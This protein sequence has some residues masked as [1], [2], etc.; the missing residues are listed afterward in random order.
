MSDIFKKNISIKFEVNRIFSYSFFK[1]NNTL[2]NRISLKNE[3]NE[4]YFDIIL[5]IFFD[6]DLVSYKEIFIKELQKKDT[7]TIEEFDKKV[8][9]DLLK[10]VTRRYFSKLNFELRDSYQNVI[11]FETVQI[12]V[13]PINF[14]SGENYS[15]ETIS[16]FINPNDDYIKDVI[17]RANK[18]SLKLKGSKF[19]GYQNNDINELK[20]EIEIVYLDVLKNKFKESEL[21][22]NYFKDGTYVKFPKEI[23]KTKEANT[24]DL[25]LFFAGIFEYL[26][27][28][29]ILVFLNNKVLVGVWANSETFAST[30]SDNNSVLINYS[31]EGEKRIFLF[32]PSSIFNSETF[33]K[34]NIKALEEIKKDNSFFLMLDLRMCR[35]NAFKPIL[36][37][38]KDL[39]E[40]Y[41]IDLKSLSLPDIDIEDA[42]EIIKEEDSK[43]DRF[44]IWKKKLLDLSLSNRLINMKIGVMSYQL[45]SPDIYKVSDLLSFSDTRI[46]L[47]SLKSLKAPSSFSKE[48]IDVKGEEIYRQVGEENLLQKR[49]Q[50]FLSEKEYQTCLT[51]LY[52]KT[53]SD[54]EE[55]GSNTLYIALGLV[56]WKQ[57][58]QVKKSNYA[59]IVLFPCELIKKPNKEFSIKVRDQEPILNTTFFAYLKE[60]FDIDLDYLNDV[61]YKENGYTVDLKL[62]FNTIKRHIV[63]EKGFRLFESAFIGRF[64]FSKYIMWND[65]KKKK[66][67]MLNNPLIRCFALKEGYSLPKKGIKTNDIDEA[68][69]IKDVAIPL[70]SDSSQIEAIIDAS[71]GDSFVLIGPPGT[72]KSQT[73]ANMIVNS[74][75]NGKKVLFCSE[76]KAALDVVYSRL[77]NLRI[78]PFCLEL[79]SNKQDKKEVLNSLNSTLELGEIEG[80][81]KFNQITRNISDSKEV[82]RDIVF[83][84]HST[85]NFPL[86]LYDAI[87]EYQKYENVEK[88]L[89]I[90]ETFV[91]SYTLNKHKEVSNLFRKAQNFSR[92]FNK[93]SENPFRIYEKR[94]YSLETKLSLKNL[95]SE[96][97]KNLSSFIALYKE[98]N[99]S[100]NLS[101]FTSSKLKDLS[102][103]FDDL[104][105]KE[106]IKELLFK[107]DPLK[108]LN[109]INDDLTLEKEAS[110]IK[111]EILK[112][113]EEKVIE[114]DVDRYLFLLEQN[115]SY[116]FIKKYFE[117]KKILKVFK[118][119]AYK[120][121]DVNKTNLNELLLN[122]ASYKKLR[123]DVKKNSI[124]LKDLFNNDYLTGFINYDELLTKVNNTKIIAYK[125]HSLTSEE[126]DFETLTNYIFELKSTKANR[127]SI[128]KYQYLYKKIDEDLSTLKNEYNFNFSSLK[129]ETYYV[130]LF[131]LF[132]G[133]LKNID[134]VNEWSNLLFIL[135]EFDTYELYKVKE[136]Y[137][138]DFNNF[139][140]LYLSFNKG[141][142]FKIIQKLIVENKLKNFLG[143]NI[144]EIKKEYV[145]LDK[146][147][148][149]EIIKEVVS[150]LSRNLPTF[151]N[152]SIN[153]SEVGILK[154]AILNKGRGLTLRKLFS[155]IPST[156]LKLTP[157]VLVSPISCA[158]YLDP[159]LYHFDVVIFDEASQLPTSDAIGV[160]SRGDSVII[161]GDD[162][163]LPP[164]S[165]FDRQINNEDE[166][167]FL[168]DLESVLDDAL[169]S[170]FEKK[171]LLYHYRS[172]NESLIAFSN[173]RFYENSLYTFPSSDEVESKVKYINVN[174]VYDSGRS[175]TNKEEANAIISN[176]KERVKNNPN[177]YSFGIIT[178]SIHQM[179]LIEDLLEEEL[180]KDKEF[181]EAYSSL[182]ESIFVK[183]LENVQGDERDIIYLSICYGRNKN[184]RFIQNFGPINNAGGYRR[185]NVAI[186]RSRVEMFVYSSISY[187]DI[188]LSKTN[189]EGAKYLKYF[190]EFAEHGLSSLAIRN[191]SFYVKEGIETYIASDLIKKGYEVKLHLGSSKFKIDIAVVSP[192]DK[193]SYLLAIIIDGY[194][195]ASIPTV[196]DR[197]IIEFNVLESLGWNTM[198]IWSLDYF[199]S[200]EKVISRIEERIQE[201]LKKKEEVKKIKE[202]DYSKVEFKRIEKQKEKLNKKYLKYSVLKNYNEN[203]F[204]A[205]VNRSAI[206]KIINSI[207]EVEAP[208]SRTIL[209]K[210]LFEIFAISRKSEKINKVIKFIFSYIKFPTSISYEE[211]FYFLSEEQIKNVGYYR[212]PSSRK[213]EEI[214]KEEIF[215]LLIEILKEEISIEE[216]A[217][218]KEISKRLGYKKFTIKQDEVLNEVISF[219]ENKKAIKRKENKFI[220]LV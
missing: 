160:I 91:D 23:I 167:L 130:E 62:V 159:N 220:E 44:S 18:E 155:L 21:P 186:T 163:Q 53:K 149:E 127:A 22:F 166:D 3:T 46:D 83:K 35:L 34:S 143:M 118:K 202:I 30:I 29:S 181:L 121:K 2:I 112:V 134:L 24:L 190:L 59:P 154:K 94:Y 1:G 107:K 156:I 51:N 128:E 39:E 4:D 100:L 116:N 114:E 197:N 73:I 142:Y 210:R 47:L 150:R 199:D 213:M 52:R 174:G 195:Y 96:V 170:N 106:V 102:L 194:Q 63:S 198:M 193:N 85:K 33:L 70:S 153:A 28:N 11:S 97:S 93:F 200:K 111:K 13:L 188:D 26:S 81:L 122:I 208:I 138:K 123:V 69:N 92:F 71:L 161:A 218:K 129:E 43:K 215:V 48:L 179:N 49:I 15:F 165:F 55:T 101:S 144:D 216:S 14:F 50:L 79:H 147:Y 131:N 171:N 196:K 205:S 72:G 214:A 65:I 109:K 139:D 203:Q 125:I 40:E 10:G 74:L 119:H 217:L 64:S 133:I 41:E 76:K 137:F 201:A 9:E 77:Q 148:K 187:L 140:D 152:K 169:A 173:S 178:F 68:I 168:Q 38:K 88:T 192:N 151:I 17:Y 110:N 5:H 180:D 84:M 108:F 89:E 78:D 66:D 58:F 207:I 20:K 37:N 90:K 209:I 117:D 124:V 162:K 82:L 54:I 115:K 98:F 164:T 25:S 191:N 8:N 99:K 87:L 103:L 212:I 60:E 184:G 6:D 16:T 145:E 45:L 219:A 57:D 36:F 104:N 206:L 27:L 32:D 158:K 12:E 172:K 182:K 136:E 185:L 183:N 80:S 7:L 204:L 175:S 120:P 31:L 141:L 177:N 75:Y 113:F 211:K 126:L 135:D 95:V 61:P 105:Q 146:E 189:S 132:E 157:C 86:S 67:D 42:R 19:L 56:G 176:L